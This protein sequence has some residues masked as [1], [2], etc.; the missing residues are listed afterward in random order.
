MWKWFFTIFVDFT[1][2]FNLLFQEESPVIYL[3]V[4]DKFTEKLGTP[5]YH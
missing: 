3:V 4:C 2:Y 5:E 1:E